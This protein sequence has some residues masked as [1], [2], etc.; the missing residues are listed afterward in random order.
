MRANWDVTILDDDGNIL[1]VIHAPSI[2]M[3]MLQLETDYPSHVPSNLEQLRTWA[4]NRK[5]K[6]MT[7][8]KLPYTP[9][10][11]T[12]KQRRWIK[13]LIDTRE[14]YKTITSNTSEIV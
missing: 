2:K 14:K 10:T 13:K 11:Q 6:N 1:G 5:G 9:L 8:V 7:F 12:E 4:K 3:V